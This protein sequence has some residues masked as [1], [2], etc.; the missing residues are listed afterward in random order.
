LLA[1][2]PGA[3]AAQVAFIVATSACW[4]E[5]VR[6]RREDVQLESGWVHVRGTKRAAR[7]RRIAI[8]HPALAS[9]LGYALKHAP[10]LPGLNQR[11]F[12]GPLKA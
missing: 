7:N 8:R 11:P 10:A 9:L 3:R 12:C 6:A 4:S 1:K 2:L 5:S